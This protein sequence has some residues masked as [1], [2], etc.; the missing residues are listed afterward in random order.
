MTDLTGLTAQPRAHID[1]AEAPARVREA[2]ARVLPHYEH[3]RRH[4]LVP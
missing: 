1:I 4:R 3:L 2:H